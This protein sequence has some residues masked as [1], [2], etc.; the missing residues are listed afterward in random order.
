VLL[1]RFIDF[2]VSPISS[3]PRF[4]SALKHASISSFHLQLF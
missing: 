4:P 1:K 2:L 3:S